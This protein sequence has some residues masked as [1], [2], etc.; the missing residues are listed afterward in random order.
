MSSPR[1]KQIQDGW[2]IAPVSPAAGVL[3]LAEGL[4][5]TKVITANT[6]FSVVNAPDGV[7]FNVVVT[8]PDPGFALTWWSGCNWASGTAPALPAGRTTVCSFIRTGSTYQAAAVLDWVQLI[9]LASIVWAKMEDIASGVIAGR[10]TEG[11][12]P[13]EWLTPAQVLSLLNLAVPPVT[14]LDHIADGASTST[15]GT[16]DDLFT[17][18]LDAGLLA[19]NGEKVMAKTHVQTVPQHIADTRRIKQ[20]F[21]GTLIWD[22]GALTLAAGSDFEISTVIIRKD[23]TTALCLVSVVTTS[24]STVPCVQQ[25]VV[26]ATL[27]EAQILKTTGIAAGTGAAS[28]DI[29]ATMGTAQWQPAAA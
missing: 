6:T 29:V 5:F 17:D 7:P 23:A 22:S 13:L 24:V 10:A 15:D 2:P 12:G 3:N 27:S 25:T 16:E 28:G 1:A 11:T 8:M 19:V 26:T 9:A 21:G 18:T 20:Y 4:L 14:I